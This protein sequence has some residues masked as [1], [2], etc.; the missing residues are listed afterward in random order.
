MPWT[1]ARKASRAKLRLF[2]TMA[3]GSDHS[4][5]A[6]ARE[7]SKVFGSLCIPLFSRGIMV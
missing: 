2:R 4:F 1:K 6:T 5:Q 3:L 7:S